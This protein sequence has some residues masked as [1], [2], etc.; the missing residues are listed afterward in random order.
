MTNNR[1]TSHRTT[2]PI[3]ITVDMKTKMII[4]RW[5]VNAFLQGR[6]KIIDNSYKILHELAQDMNDV[7]DVGSS[8]SEINK[9][10]NKATILTGIRNGI[11]CMSRELV[12]LFHGKRT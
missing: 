12:L 4:G 7:C 10:S 5:Q 2:G 11:I 9:S 1:A 3:R 8:N 6:L